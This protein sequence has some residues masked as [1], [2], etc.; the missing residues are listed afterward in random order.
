MAGFDFRILYES[1]FR[2]REDKSASM[3]S[4]ALRSLGPPAHAANI[5]TASAPPNPFFKNVLHNP[6][7]DFI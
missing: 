1:R 2:F 3:A 5:N 6:L 7:T 4:P